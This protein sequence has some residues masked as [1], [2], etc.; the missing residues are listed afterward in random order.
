MTLT[1]DNANSTDNVENVVTVGSEQSEL[2]EFTSLN[3][4]AKALGVTWKTAKKHEGRGLFQKVRTGA[5]RGKYHV[6]TCV[7][8]Y[9][10][11]RDPDNVA[12]GVAGA[13]HHGV[14]KGGAIDITAPTPLMVH[15]AAKEKLEA[16]KKELQLRQMRGELIE[17]DAAIEAVQAIASTI[18]E[19]IEGAASQ[20]AVRVAGVSNQVECERIARGVLRSV[21]RDLADLGNGLE[22]GS[23]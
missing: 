19:R 13:A 10:A 20:I 4:V 17:R 16:E 12:K 23:G 2:P 6:P 3:G 7:E 9:N 11:N 22:G 1:I 21:Q 14:D 5:N 18:K 15:R 8:A